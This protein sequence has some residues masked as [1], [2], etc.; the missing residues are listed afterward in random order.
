[1][2]SWSPRSSSDLL[3][4]SSFGRANFASFGFQGKAVES[5]DSLKAL[6]G[7]DEAEGL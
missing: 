1:M 4:V 3:K 7:R 6:G 2:G 5:D